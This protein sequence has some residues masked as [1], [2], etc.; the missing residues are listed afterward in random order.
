MGSSWEG[1]LSLSSRRRTGIPWI[2]STPGFRSPTP[3]SPLVE[4]RPLGAQGRVLAVAGGEPGL[5]GEPVEQLRPYVV[6]QRPE[7]VRVPAGVPHATGEERVTG[8]QV[9]GSSRVVVQQRHRTG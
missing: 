2:D 5:V 1:R 4:V 6:Q 3:R 7:V 8:P 9:R